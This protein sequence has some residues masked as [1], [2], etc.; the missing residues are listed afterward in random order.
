[1]DQL[2][3]TPHLEMPSNHAGLYCQEA[4]AVRPNSTDEI[5]L[6]SRVLIPWDEKRN[7]GGSIHRSNCCVQSEEDFDLNYRRTRTAFE[8]GGS[9]ANRVKVLGLILLFFTA[10]S[11][12]ADIAGLGSNVT[13]TW[14]V[15]ISNPR[16]RILGIAELTQSGS[17]VTGWLEP[18]GGD[19]IPISGALLS[20]RLVITTH[21]ESRRLVAFD[22]C[23]LD[24]GSNHM[25]GTFFPGKGK[26]EFI[27]VREPRFSTRPRDWRRP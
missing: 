18:N 21:P 15:K 25:K 23:E 17:Q 13:G 9:M 26:I 14:T 2:G 22:R 12:S 4:D 16:V 6:L 19:R 10:S 11:L 27:K 8:L 5:P 20:N 7:I 1:M 3:L 24:A